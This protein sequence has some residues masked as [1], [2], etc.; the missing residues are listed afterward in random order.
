MS[1]PLAL[2]TDSADRPRTFRQEGAR[3]RGRGGS[4]GPR[5]PDLASLTPVAPRHAS[6]WWCPFRAILRWPQSNSP[7]SW[8]H[9]ASTAKPPA[10]L[11][12]EVYAPIIYHLYNHS[13]AILAK[14]HTLSGSGSAMGFTWCFAPF[15]QGHVL[16]N[17]CPF[18]HRAIS[19]HDDTRV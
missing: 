1:V 6:R 8:H 10:L 2:L 16:I 4:S 3:E 7:D 15:V 18:S 14:L 11:R 12:I 13:L 17:M 5:L 9:P 19:P